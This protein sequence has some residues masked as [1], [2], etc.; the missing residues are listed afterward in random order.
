MFLCVCGGCPAE[1]CCPYSAVPTKLHF[2]RSLV[3]LVVRMN[4]VTL[5]D[6][7]EGAG[8]GRKS[9]AGC[10]KGKLPPAVP[11]FFSS[12]CPSQ[13]IRSRR[14]W[15]EDREPSSSWGLLCPGQEGCVVA[16]PQGFGDKEPHSRL[17]RPSSRWGGGSG[18]ELQPCRVNGTPGLDPRAPNLSPVLLLLCSQCLTNSL[19]F[20][21]CLF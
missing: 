4:S 8:G 11:L 3:S 13:P 18:S 16:Q 5:F 2:S 21:W 20:S 15:K 10:R 6:G 12:C 14:G 1:V 17:C 9:P 7:Q 19:G